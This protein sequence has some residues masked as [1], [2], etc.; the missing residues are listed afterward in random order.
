MNKRVIKIDNVNAPA[1]AHVT[2]PALAPAH[3]I[4]PFTAPASLLAPAA[5]PDSRSEGETLTHW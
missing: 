1:P 5:F 3:I 2:A 4:V